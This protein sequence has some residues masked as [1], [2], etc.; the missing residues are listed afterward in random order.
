MS[1]PRDT[2]RSM[3]TELV[4]LRRQVLELQQALAQVE[5]TRGP[6]HAS[7]LSATQVGTW[8][9]D[10]CTNRVLWSPETEN[11]FGIPPG[12]FDGTYEGFFA[13]V[14]PDDRQRLQ[15]GIAK[16]VEDRTPYRIE[17]RIITL[18]ESVRW[19]ACRG[20]ATFRNNEPVTGMVGTIEDITAQK[21]WELAQQDVRDMLERQ[22]SERTATLEQAIT[23]LKQEVERRRDAE[24]ALKASEQR[25]QSL[26]EQN[27][28]MYFTLT[29]DGTVL[30]VNQFGAAQLGYE[31]E[32]LVGQSI[33]NVFD[34]KDHQA[35]QAQLKAC[36]ASPYT[37]FQWDVHKTRNDGTRLWVKERARA[38]HDQT[39]QLL[40]LIS[41]EDITER[42]DAEDRF[43]DNETR[44]IAGEF[45][46]QESEQALRASELKFRTFVETTRDWVWEV[47]EHA[48]YT[49]A[50]PRI[51]EI[52]G[53]EPEEVIGKTPFDLMPP[54]EAIRVAGL[55]GPIAAARQPFTLLENTNHHKNGRLVVLETSGTP[56]FDSTG[57]FRGY[58]G[59]DRDIADR[60]RTEETLRASELRLQRFV[61]EAPVGLAILDENWRAISA[62]KAL[63]ELT[64]YE[65]HEIVGSTYALYTHPDD[66]AANIQL[67]DE[68]L[69][70][71]FILGINVE[72][73]MDCATWQPEPSKSPRSLPCRAHRGREPV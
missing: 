49:Y 18:E 46:R 37:L 65:E 34:V 72:P 4:D 29:T 15:A 24:S 45:D 66:L 57:T 56:I 36:V 5:H 40:I 16:A 50:S 13:R 23:D 33:M 10:S 67:T 22:V 12:S 20:R 38:I 17:H 51:R 26:Y 11:I 61:A 7:A 59:I 55:F 47:N 2:D 25:Y 70:S 31:K 68:F 8:E 48:I 27:P 14:H 62:N 43:R 54:E 30:S 1:T 3:S 44:W 69:A 35:V 41:C 58:H 39:S 52:L 21:E 71:G 53:Y 42:R 73:V 19:V 6:E 9:W 28:F 60:K 63:C 32:D 64:G